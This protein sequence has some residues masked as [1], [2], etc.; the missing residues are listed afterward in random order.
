MH[1]KFICV[2]GK[3]SDA[4]T[5]ETSGILTL[6]LSVNDRFAAYFH[7]L[8]ALCM[9]GLMVF[10]FAPFGYW[11]LQIVALAVLFQLVHHNRST[12]Q[13][14]LV[15]LAFGFGSSLSCVH[16]LYV[17]MHRYGGMPAWM[18]IVAVIL[19]SLVLAL[20]PAMATASGAYLQ[21][22][23]RTH[24]AVTLLLILPA[25]WTLSEW[26]RGWVLTGFPWCALGY[27][28]STS[29]LAG[30]APVFGVFG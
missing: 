14:A 30:L 5:R 12:G 13:S 10:S 2:S 28:H 27:A 9:G 7:Y 4:I 3:T 21:K 19:F 25:L 15:G 29:P 26:L 20:F 8:V 23:F 6:L 11:P 18:A 24:Q 1:A 17:S 22:R 16:W